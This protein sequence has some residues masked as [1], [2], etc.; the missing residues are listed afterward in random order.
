MSKQKSYVYKCTHKKT[1]E[2]YFG[3][4]KAN[5]VPPNEDLGTSYFTSSK[6]IKNRFSEFYYEVIEEFDDPYEALNLERKL[7]LENIGNPMLLNSAYW[8]KHLV[9]REQYNTPERSRKIREVRKKHMATWVNP[10]S[11]KECVEKV[12]LS[13]IGIKNPNFGVRGCFSHNNTVDSC[14]ICGK[15]TTLV[16]LKRHHGTG[17]CDKIYELVDNKT[18]SVITSKDLNRICEEKGIYIGTAKY[19]IKNSGYFLDRYSINNIMV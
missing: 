4:R 1:A 15:R 14:K 11:K 10:M 3:F 19:A 2:F 12:R 5:K 13:K 6:K 16:H 9:T 18:N 17:K 8:H 7:I